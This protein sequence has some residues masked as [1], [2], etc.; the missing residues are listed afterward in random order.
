MSF[1]DPPPVE[2][3][4]PTRKMSSP[5]PKRL[6]ERTKGCPIRV[7]GVAPVASRGCHGQFPSAGRRPRS[8]GPAT[9]EL[10]ANPCSCRPS[11]G[12]WRFAVLCSLRRPSKNRVVYHLR[13]I[14]EIV[15]R[16]TQRDRSTHLALT[17]HVP[18]LLRRAALGRRPQQ[19]VRLELLWTKA[20]S[21]QQS[22]CRRRGTLG[23]RT[24]HER[25]GNGASVD[26]TNGPPSDS[27]WRSHH[28]DSTSWYSEDALFSVG[29]PR[30]PSSR[31]VKA[32]QQELGL[33]RCV[34]AAS[35]W[36][37]AGRMAT[38]EG[39]DGRDRDEQLIKV[40]RSGGVQRA[41]C[42]ASG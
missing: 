28:I 39:S 14:Q 12:C 19:T 30:F 1:Q 40:A 37:V 41:G 13:W 10:A 35:D 16:P 21:T 24:L 26:G 15:E 33:S 2:Q 9:V 31:K 6:Q 36:G 3:D 18:Q 22:S 34:A 5:T 32:R 20:P 25:R 27:F 38:S 4:R 8:A 23:T 17:G 42:H 29:T 11:T 7:A